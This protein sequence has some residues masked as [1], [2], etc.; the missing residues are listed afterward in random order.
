MAAVYLGDSAV[1]A[2]MVCVV[3]LLGGAVY[4]AINREWIPNFG[5]A[6]KLRPLKATEGAFGSGGL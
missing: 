3:G 6:L 1:L 2:T 5:A 4:T